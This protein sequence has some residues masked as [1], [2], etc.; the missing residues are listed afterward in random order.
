MTTADSARNNDRPTGQALRVA[1]VILAAGTGS[2]LGGVAK[3]LIRV[4]GV[5]MVQRQVDVLR[6]AGVTDIVVV[7]GV[8][9]DAIAQVVAARG[10][11]CVHNADAARG[12]GSSVRLGLQRSSPKADAVLLVLC[13]QPLLTAA[14]LADLIAAFRNRGDHDFV[15]PWVDGTRRGNPVAASRRVVQAILSGDQY[16]ACRDY[17][18]AHPESVL[19]LETANDHYVVDIDRPQD[20]VALSTRLGGAVMLPTPV[21]RTRA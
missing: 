2:R 7:A 5:P 21:E 18:D 11:R 9:H 4:D 13:D 20:L 8:H 16:Q 15:V 1:A 14:D 3:A 10:V 6:G 17:M 19:R 12:Q